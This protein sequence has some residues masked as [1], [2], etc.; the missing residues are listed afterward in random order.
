MRIIKWDGTL[1]ALSGIAHNDRD[2]GIK[3]GFRRETI[4]TAT[5]ERLS[6]VPVLSGA[7]IRGDMR[8]LAAA[9]AQHAIVGDGRLPFD[10]VHTLV[11]GGSLRSAPQGVEVLSGEKQAAIRDLIPMLGIFGFTG[12]SRIASGRL[13]VD[14]AIP[15]AQET[16]HLAPEGHEVVYEQQPSI[17]E[18]IQTETYTRNADVTDARMQPFIEPGGSR[19]I[20]RGSGQMRWDQETIPAGARLFHSVVLDQGTPSEV[21][22]MDELMMRWS[23][24]GR[25]GAHKARGLGRIRTNYQ[26]HC[27]D[28]LGDP[29]PEETGPG[30]RE[31]TEQNLDKV[32]EALSWLL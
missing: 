29:A 20:P 2:T 27:L 21:S 9:M 10:A 14:K 26:R 4:I 8:R 28:M 5:G 12:R 18:L 13:Y 15:V 25:V 17:W 6:G 11:S 3:H 16:A 23:R 30:W 19:E 24:R 31:H 1:T 7:V 32:H 22:F